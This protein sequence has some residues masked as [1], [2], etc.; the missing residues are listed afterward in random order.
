MAA[1][2]TISL[3]RNGRNQALRIPRDL[4]LPAEQAQI[5]RDGEKLVIEPL[6]TPPLLTLLDSWQPLDVDFP[7][8]DNALAPLDDVSI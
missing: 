2:R 1:K 8:I 4:E 3:F 7:E 5:Y 6:T